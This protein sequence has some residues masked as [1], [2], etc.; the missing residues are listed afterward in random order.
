MLTIEKLEN[1]IQVVLEEMAM[2][3]AFPLVSG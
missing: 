2:S 3:A 1:G